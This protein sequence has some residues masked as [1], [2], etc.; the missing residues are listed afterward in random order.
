MSTSQ[1]LLVPVYIDTNA[2]LDLLASIESGFTLVE[3][4]T[5]MRSEEKSV[6]KGISADVGT[7]FGIPNVLSILK[8]G[9]RGSAD[10][11]KGEGSDERVEAQRYHTYGS[12]LHRLRLFLSREG[13][14]KP[15]STDQDWQSISPSDFVEFHG[16]I[17]PNPL[18]DSLQRLDRLLGI[19]QILGPDAF[20]GSTTQSKP[21]SAAK[22][23]KQIRDFF[24]GVL[25]DIEG[26]NVRKFVVEVSTFKECKAVAL[27]FLDYLRDK[28]MAEIAFKEYKILGKIVRKIEPSSEESID[29]L[30]GTGLGGIG[31]DSLSKLLGGLG[32]LEG[33]D[34]PPVVTE[35]AGP[36]LEVVPIAVFI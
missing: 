36:S 7:E 24:A 4:I 15:F 33:M 16:L 17:R 29:L 31:R 30:S 26:E 9:L 12:L 5:T 20:T 8:L 32:D 14:L 2:L 6:A 3:K 23:M 10:V 21:K 25:N 35:I 1:G 19:I 22:Q 28:T 27:L 18:T 11:T 13:L 34:L